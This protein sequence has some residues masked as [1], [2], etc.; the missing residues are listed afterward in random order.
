MTSIII[1]PTKRKDEGSSS[2]KIQAF[3]I[4]GGTA[5]GKT[6]VQNSLIKKLPNNSKVLVVLHQHAKSFG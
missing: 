2:G 3:I 4:S 1:N 6:T 5:T